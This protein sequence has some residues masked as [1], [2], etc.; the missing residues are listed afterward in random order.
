VVCS[1]GSGPGP[2]LCDGIDNDCN[3]IVDDVA[4]LGSPCTVLWGCPG[5]W[6]C[7]EIGDL[8]CE[9]AASAV[10]VCNG[11]DD[12]CDGKTDEEPDITNNDLLLGVECDKP[13]AGE[14]PG[15]CHSGITICQA[16]KV[17]CDGSVVAKTEI[18]D[19][20][21][22]DCDGSIDEGVLCVTGLS[23]YQGHCVSPCGTGDFPC[24]GGFF[25]SNGYCLQGGLGTGGTG[26]TG[27]ATTGAG[28]SSSGNGG[29][30]STG[31]ASATSGTTTA[32]ANAGGANSSAGGAWYG[33]T[34]STG[35]TG[36]TTTAVADAGAA[37][38]SAGGASS[39]STDTS[40][41]GATNGTTT[42]VTNASGG[43][44]IGA[45]GASAGNTDTSN[46]GAS[47]GTT[48]GVTNAGGANSSAGGSSS[49]IAGA[50]G[51]A[52]MG[53][54][55][56]SATTNGSG[57]EPAS[58]EAQQNG[59]CGC[60]VPG[61]DRTDPRLTL[62]FIAAIGAGFKRRQRKVRPGGVR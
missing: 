5:A 50:T 19:G 20:I 30:P 55:V 59:G 7:N 52:G 22:N 2:E 41:T 31:A 42:A 34:S 35:A 9:L 10:E 21:D 39:G 56:S 48:T 18:C 25:C 54:G 51:T 26:A 1:G 38:S 37:N 4:E 53:T 28:G 40:S 17:V 12:D 29:T 45:G 8:S 32:V 13:S 15:T 14:T 43:A 27:T 46:T 11:I 58:G 16:G 36:G 6:K 62:L 60:S 47:S 61:Q 57:T 23:C 49:A 3:G 33:N 24:P 44:N